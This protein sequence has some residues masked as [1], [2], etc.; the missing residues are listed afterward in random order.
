MDR[1]RRRLIRFGGQLIGA[2]ALGGSSWRVLTGPDPDA[3]FSQPKGPYVWRIN[4]DKCTFCGR[5]ETACVRDRSAV[6]AVNDQKKCSYCVACYGHI[7]DLNVSSALIDSKG[8][9]VCPH[10]AVKRD[11]FSG[12]EDGYHLY[13]IDEATCTAC[14]KC[15]K[16]CNELGTRSM[17][18]IIRPDLCIGCNRCAIA[19]VCPDDA[20]EWAHSYPEDDF[21][22]D[23][24]L[25]GLLP[26]MGGEEWMSG[27]P[28]I[29]S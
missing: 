19:A 10:D 28:G 14:G 13:T 23:F 7:S 22:G 24:E 11:R 3:V 15:A 18:L 4:P 29:D 9:R 17:F 27:Q 26:D 16:R 5:C 1:G 8:L 25:E 12:G 2:A 20:V 21:R 6:K